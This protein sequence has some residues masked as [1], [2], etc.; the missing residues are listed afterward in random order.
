MDRVVSARRRVFGVL[1]TFAFVTAVSASAVAQAVA[2]TITVRAGDNLQAA[3]DASQPGDIILLEAGATFLGNFTLPV[4]SGASY[5]TVRS[6]TPDQYLP[7]AGTRVTP[8][9]AP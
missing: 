1:R 9:H 4:K 2:G 3:L 8:L 7:P 5:I 6:S